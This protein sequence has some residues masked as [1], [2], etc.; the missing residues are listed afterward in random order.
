LGRKKMK[1]TGFTI[2]IWGLLLAFCMNIHAEAIDQQSYL[3]T[4]E[5][6]TE[7]RT[8]VWPDGARYEGEWTNN[9]PHGYGSL[10]YA[11]GAQYW[12]RFD[13]GRRQGHGV[14]KYANG[15]EYEG[16]WH[17]DQPQGTGVR[18]FAAGSIYEGEFKDGLQEG[19]GKQTYIDNT[20]YKGSWHQGK[21]HGYGKLTFIS[22]GEYEGSFNNGKPHGKGHYYYPNGDVY[23]GE[24]RDGNQDGIGRID[25]STGGFYEGEFVEGMRHGDGVMVSAM[26]N[27]YDGS[28]E[29]NNA[30]G[31]GTCT[32]A[33]KSRPCQYR[34]NKLMKN[35][36][37]AKT[38]A[39]T[40]TA[41]VA[42]AT[43]ASAAVV[44]NTTQTAN[45]AKPKPKASSKPKPKPK[46]KPKPKQLAAAVKPAPVPVAKPFIM[47]EET[48]TDAVPP[49]QKYAA[50]MAIP[51]SKQIFTKTLKQEK[52]ALKHLTVADL[53]QD[54]SDIYFSDNW[55]ERDLM[56]IPEQ[57]WWQKR[58]SLFADAVHIVSVH[59]D[60]EIRMVIGD[61]QGP[62][63]YDIKE[64]IV[65]SKSADLD[66]RDLK[67]GTIVV[68]SEQDSWISG[69]FQFEVDDG[70]GQHL[71]FNHGAFRLNTKDNLPL[72]RR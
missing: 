50:A 25:Y 16:N 14:M 43:V 55:E 36:T 34:R 37:L 66:A 24:W 23:S 15:D 52:Q 60:T 68:E 11:N 21:P 61:Y 70:D 62:G 26:G 22:G 35:T 2:G 46:S 56:S 72:L 17:K 28:F 38:K 6:Q 20:Y 71:A 45:K 67:S 63:S 59:G 5:Y 33:G 54:R 65:A 32:S 9:Q 69:S 7:H 30:H 48:Q 57:A 12:G 18:R 42:L 31:E 39:P 29:L 4:T 51:D 41:T 27:K 19:Q 1:T 44:T 58:A 64:V 53:R 13:H 40:T 3:N 10:T 47:A 8:H 49:K